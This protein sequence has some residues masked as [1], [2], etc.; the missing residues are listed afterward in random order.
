MVCTEALE[1]MYLYLDQEVLSEDERLEIEAHLN[2]CPFCFQRYE[3]ESS[4]WS[5]IRKTSLE[6]PLPES[7]FTRIEM[8]IA[9]F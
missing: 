6:A 1:K 4:L 8:F 2:A 7:L 3:F 5:L 9:G